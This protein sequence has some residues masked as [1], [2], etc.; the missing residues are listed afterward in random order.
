MLHLQDILWL[1]TSS[2]SHVQFFVT[3]W[4]VAK[5]FSGKN[6][7]V[8]YHFLHQGIL[9]THGSNPSLLCLLYCRQILYLPSPW[10]SPKYSIWLTK[11]TYQNYLWKI[12]GVYL[13]SLR[14]N[15]TTSQISVLHS[16]DSWLDQSNQQ[17]HHPP[18]IL[19]SHLLWSCFS[20]QLICW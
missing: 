16:Q 11:N 19:L 6:T 17:Q 7:G 8:G 4:T 3:L 10:V 18:S 12:V 14:S 9:L 1:P 15:Y 2:L 5:D 13:I 20:L